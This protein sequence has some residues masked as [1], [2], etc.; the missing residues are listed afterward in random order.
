MEVFMI[1][2]TTTLGTDKYQRLSKTSTL[3]KS[4]HFDSYFHHYFYSCK[5][6]DT[7]KQ[8]QNGFRDNSP[9]VIQSTLIDLTGSSA[10]SLKVLMRGY[11]I[12]T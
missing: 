1:A 6:T 2:E 9:P 5:D 12:E 8:S 4:R 7:R 11:F 10:T 3:Y